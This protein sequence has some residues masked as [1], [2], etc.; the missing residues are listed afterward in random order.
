MS[1]GNPFGARA[2]LGPG[3]PDFYRLSALAQGGGTKAALST[4]LGRLPVTIK[5]LLE[6]VLR[7]AGGGIVRE[8]DVVA[9]AGWQPGAA[10]TSGATPVEIPFMPARVIMQDFTGVPAVVD[11]AAMRDAMAELGGDPARVNPLVPADLVIDHSVQVD[12]YGTAGA[13]AFNVE[14]EYERNGERY[15][16]LRWAQTAFDDLRV[17]PPGTGIVHQVNLEYLASVVA[18][19]RDQ[20]GTGEVAFPD[21]LVGTDSHTTMINGLGVLGYGVGGIEAEAV[22]LGQPL[23][24]PMPKVI[25][26][27]LS[28]ELPEGATATDLVLVVTQMLR[29]YG[30]VGTFV[31][32][33]GD[34]LAGLALA[35][36]ATISNMSPE[37][38]ATA[39]LFPIDVETLAYLRLTGRTDD[40]IALVERYAKEQGLWRL[41]GATPDF[42]ALLTLDLGSV[43]PSL[44]GPRRPQDRVA[45]RDLGANFRAAFPEGL[46]VE[47]AVAGVGAGLAA[48]APNQADSAGSAASESA[49]AGAAAA[50]YPRVRVEA[51]GRTIEVANG[52]VA[53]AAITSCTNTSNPTVMVAAGLLA[54]NAVARGLSVPPTVKTSLAPGSRAVTEY[55]RGAGL[56]EPLDK[57]GFA[58]VGYGCTTCIGNS[59]PLDAPVAKA[60]DE[61]DLV[62][63]A[64]LSGNRNFDG[65]IH[66]L[67]RASY[68]ASPPLVV[69]FALAGTVDVDL[70]TQALGVG[71]DGRPVF[72]RDL[73]PPAEEVR[74]TVGSAVSSELFLSAYA[75]VFDGGPQWKAL[76][77]PSGNRYRWDSGSTYV[78]LPPF[79]VGLRPEP[80]PVEAIEGARALCVLGDSVTTDHISPAGS[81]AA[82]SPAGQWLQARGV[83][84]VE[85]NSYGARRGHHE[86]MVRGTFANIRLHNAL[87]GREGPF[88][89][90][91][92]DG[93]P[94]TIFDAAMRYA[95]EGVPL[96]VIA[97]KEYGSGSSR[98]W[99]AKG[100]RLLGVRAVIAESF[101]RIHR[102]N[103]VGMGILPLQFLAGES[104]ASLGLTGRE[105]YTIELPVDGPAPR[106]RVTILARADDRVERRFQA[107]ARLD[108]PIELD[109]YRQGGI[110]PAVLRRLA[111]DAAGT[112]DPRSAART[113][114]EPASD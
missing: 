9:L 107:T 72:L 49:A 62:V 86:V 84:P 96:I 44:A 92:P 102:S 97:G 99:A 68:L 93:E 54:R 76:D 1:A 37:F 46:E 25:G 57:L 80:A 103:L 111:R 63:A 85:F 42:D 61:N 69:A 52:S 36:R 71:S 10:S 65:R 32:F 82:S 53:I 11:L 28:G 15:K 7:H 6:N 34:G 112:G 109:Y 51:A 78:A 45:L 73:W 100:P 16:L 47:A 105:A 114:T 101:E 13:F 89:V 22:L 66:P 110:L 58:L 33:S 27:R 20:D 21:T 31:E 106:G 74:K 40:H 59:G 38:G 94:T 50:S 5:I 41:P 104:A 56:L 35:D 95:A 60:I 48:G 19:R 79:F 18:R 43:E 87:A 29:A 67:V 88:T 91:L 77:V 12:H 70:T 64:V 98:D 2:S 90:H 81:I 30:V 8:A 23:Y 3:L 14:R 24:Q 4:D 113:S 55:L 17:V 39:T 83:P 75:S 108:G 26:V